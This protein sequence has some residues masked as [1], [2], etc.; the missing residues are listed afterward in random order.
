[1]RQ[2]P[3]GTLHYLGRTDHQI[4]LRGHRIELG[5]ID[6]TLETH[7]CI[8]QAA[9]TVHQ[10]TL[11]AYLVGT[12]IDPAGLRAHLAERLP[13]YM[14][15]TIF[16]PLA[17]L[18]LTPNGK[19]DR[20]ALPVPGVVADVPLRPRAAGAQVPLSPAQERAWFHASYLDGDAAAHLSASL[21]LT[22]RL[23]EDALAGALTR[24]ASR[25]EGLRTRFPG[26]EGRPRVVVERAYEP[27]VGR[28]DLTGRLDAEEE[29]VRLVAAVT[30]EPFD[31]AAAP[32]VRVALVRL[33][34]DDHVL[35]VV[36]H[37]VVADERS[38]GVLLDDLATLYE[39]RE[40]APLPV[41]AGDVTRWRDSRE[42]MAAPALDH[43]C[44][45]LAGAPVLDLPLDRPRP[46]TPARAGGW[47]EL[48]LP[49]EPARALER[50]G[51]GA[52]GDLFTVLLAAYQV[53]LARH[54]GQTGFL[55]GRPVDGRDLPGL[56]PVFGHLTRHLVLR[57][58]L[59][60]DPAFTELLRRTRESELEA[61]EHADL[62]PERL[63][64]ALAVERDLGRE[65]L[66]QTT[67]RMC[68][69]VPEPGT[70]GGLEHR[71][72]AARPPETVYDLALEARPAAGGL[73]L[74]F[75]YDAALLDAGTVERLA[76]RFA[77][78]LDQ[79]MNAPDRRISELPPH[80]PADEADAWPER[81]LDPWGGPVP[82][83]AAGE[84]R[85]QDG[86]VRRVRRLPDGRLETLP[87]PHV[88]G[89]ARTGFR[90]GYLAPRTDAE[91]LVADVWGDL[92]GVHKVGA[93]DDFFH[94][95][96]HSLLAVRAAARLRAT[97]GIEVPI[98]TFFT[99]R[100]VAELA[101]A[102]EEILL[103]DLENLS[104]EEALRLLDSTEAP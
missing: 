104:D 3:N 98:R 77:V 69:P 13:A 72:F 41:Q 17:A 22:G 82:P 57:G 43:W 78:L 56:E 42:S 95:G 6:T 39:G 47:H 99:H 12:S 83:G 18:P 55:I 65:P 100:T 9:T 71:P 96:G 97:V 62:S 5:D 24:L 38:M 7:P 45:R 35:C 68:E 61:A 2:N 48:R 79:V 40:P 58:D 26:D 46:E 88:V 27:P 31:L 53:L 15:P 20:K 49:P 80:T 66:F 76:G 23:D 74:V 52:G 70:F 92:L 32:P 10:D 67:L 37:P 51:A 14:I 8:T 34:A 25:H 91:A 85:T 75:Q 84:L 73:T 1:V 21:R 102:V 101:G 63:V 103:A 94:L 28:H 59:S 36:A 93:D 90:P 4:K 60:G 86:E 16:I 19:L 64:S 33:A 11:V 29:A 30:G 44:G 54:C 87:V 89:S 81:I 50:L